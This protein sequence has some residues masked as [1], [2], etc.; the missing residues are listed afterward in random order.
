[1]VTQEVAHGYSAIESVR[2]DEFMFAGRFSIEAIFVRLL[3][4]YLALIILDSAE[5]GVTLGGILVAILV[6][7]IIEAAFRGVRQRVRRAVAGGRLYRAED[8]PRILADALKRAQAEVTVFTYALPSSDVKRTLGL[9]RGISD[10]EATT[11]R[12]F[13]LAE[14]EALLLMLKQAHD[15]GANAVVGVRL[16]TGTYEANGSQ[17]QVSRPVYTGTA[18]RI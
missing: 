1:M 6:V 2:E 10:T 18:V 12:D 4:A 3:E 5:Q 7:A 13:R 11:K 8:F 9:V 17:W 15:M 14:Q 16:T